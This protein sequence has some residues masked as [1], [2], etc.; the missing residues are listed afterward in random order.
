MKALR[1]PRGHYQELKM[2]FGRNQ[3]FNRLGLPARNGHCL[4]RKTLHYVEKATEIVIPF[5][6]ALSLL[7]V[8]PKEMKQL[9]QNKTKKNCW[10]VDVHCRLLCC[11]EEIE[12]PPRIGP[13]FW[14]SL[15]AD[16]NK[17][18]APINIII[19][20]TVKKCGEIFALA[21]EEATC[22]WHVLWSCTA[23]GCMC[24]R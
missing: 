1:E 20:K 23:E 18:Y 3:I 16:L 4:L 24:V 22:K 17:Y 15:Y 6:S 13:G 8:Y 7:G 19:I 5:D 9:K 10:Q 14:E 21:N 11:W 12:K 2:T